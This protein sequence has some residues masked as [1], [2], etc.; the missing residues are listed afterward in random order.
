MKSGITASVKEFV[1][2]NGMVPSC[3]AESD[4]DM[5]ARREP[6]EQ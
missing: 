2:L 5:H 1:V 3:E 6:E 4:A